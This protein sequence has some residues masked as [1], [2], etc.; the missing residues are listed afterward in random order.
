MIEQ[1]RSEQLYIMHEYSQRLPPEV[2]W[3]VLKHGRG[4]LNE[5]TVIHVLKSG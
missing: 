2:N 5:Y 1:N 3:Y 4:Q